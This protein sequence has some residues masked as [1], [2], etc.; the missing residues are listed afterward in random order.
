MAG[1][2]IR[3]NEPTPRL[4]LTIGAIDGSLAGFAVAILHQVHHAILNNIPDNVIMHLLGELL[5]AAVGG[6]LLFVGIAALRNRS[7]EESQVTA[8]KTRMKEAIG[9]MEAKRSATIE[10]VLPIER[11]QRWHRRQ[12]LA[13]PAR[14]IFKDQSLALNCA[15]EN[16]SA[17]GACLGFAATV[18]L[19]REFALEIVSLSLRVRTRLVWSAGKRHGVMFV[20]P[21]RR[22]C[23]TAGATTIL[24]QNGVS[25][26]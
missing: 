3:G 5:V 20:W 6:A 13:C 11:D 9:T 23:G 18:D 17:G 8:E 12:P 14:L 25:C 10:G 7:E 19:P 1:V 21:Q 22:V 16:I 26:D 24:R 4:S 2:V 15:V